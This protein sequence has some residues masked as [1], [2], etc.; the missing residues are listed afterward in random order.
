MLFL[1]AVLS[2]NS[3]CFFFSLKLR[4]AVQWLGRSVVQLCPAPP[5]RWVLGSA[6]RSSRARDGSQLQP[7]STGH[8][9]RESTPTTRAQLCSLS[10]WPLRWQLS[11]FAEYVWLTS[12]YL[13]YKVVCPNSSDLNASLNILYW[14]R[15]ENCLQRLLFVFTLKS[16]WMLMYLQIHYL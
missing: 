5:P 8:S 3:Q 14:L 15:H 1:R 12:M 6:V 10:C 9:S 7:T 2:D 4:A 16:L 11:Y 13:S